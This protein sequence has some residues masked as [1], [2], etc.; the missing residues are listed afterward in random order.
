M[1]NNAA[2][3]STLYLYSDGASR[4]NPG[5]GGAGVVITDN[6]GNEVF[7]KGFYIGH[8]TNNEAE[9]KAL[10][11]GLAEASGGECDNIV[12]FLDSQLIVRQITGEYQVKNKNLIL[13]YEQVMDLLTF[14][15]R[16]RVEYIPRSQ[17]TR[18]DQ[19]ANEGLD[20]KNK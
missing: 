17:N 13:L 20:S 4:G 14:F 10:I 19:L 8:C 11:I 5:E 12:I 9:Y 18:A 2:S 7:S 1:D 15:R 3:G 16:Y 6:M